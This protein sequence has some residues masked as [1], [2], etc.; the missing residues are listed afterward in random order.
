MSDCGNFK[1]WAYSNQR[2]FRRNWCVGNNLLENGSSKPNSSSANTDVKV[3]VI[4]SILW[5]WT[6]EQYVETSKFPDLAPPNIGQH[7]EATRCFN[8]HFFS[9]YF[10]E[11]T[12]S[13]NGHVSIFFFLSI[14]RKFAIFGLTNY[15]LST[16]FKILQSR[17]VPSQ[18]A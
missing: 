18:K 14:S 1:N 8:N 13:A 4:C 5:M 2:Q 7:F 17:W 12:I 10:E 3:K 6:Y 15:F 16:K 11:L 9:Q